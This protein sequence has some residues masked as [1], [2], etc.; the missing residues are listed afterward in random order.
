[1]GGGED[2]GGFSE[3]SDGYSTGAEDKGVRVESWVRV[4]LQAEQSGWVLRLAARSWGVR[5]PQS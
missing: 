5:V 3:G 2:L 1:M 4:Q